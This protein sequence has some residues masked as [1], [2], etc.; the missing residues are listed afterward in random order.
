V[1]GAGGSQVGYNRGH[2][3]NKSRRARRGIVIARASMVL[4]V[5]ENMNNRSRKRLIYR[6]HRIDMLIAAIESLIELEQSLQDA[7]KAG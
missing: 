2:R 6:R 3:Q 5:G 4:V 1:Q 7:K